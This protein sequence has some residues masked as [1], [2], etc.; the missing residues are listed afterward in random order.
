M[1]AHINLF[2]VLILL[3]FS[4]V[5]Q[6]F[7]YAQ[8]KQPNVLFI[9][10]D[11]MNDWTT[12]FDEDYPIQTPNIEKLAERG[13]FFSHAYSSS[14]ACNPSRASVM[15]STR[16]HKTGIYG[17]LSDW[18]KTLSD[19]KTIQQYFMD[20]G[21]YVVGSGK[22]FHHSLD[23]AMHDNSSFD[24]FLL[25][26][27]NKPYPPSKKNNLEWYGSINTDWGAWPEQIEQTKDYKTVQYATQFLQREHNKPFFLNVGIYKPHSPFFAPKE[28]FEPYPI[29]SIEVPKTEDE[30]WERTSGAKH[31]LKPVEW[32]W[33]G[34]E[35]AVEEDPNIYREYV[36]AYQAASTFSDKMIG[37]VIDALDNSPYRDNTIIVLWSDHGF[38]IGEKQH[39][40]KFAL[41][42]KTT[43]VPLIFVAPDQIKPG[44]VI[45]TPVD[46][47]AI[48][49][50]L[51]ELAG[52]ENYRPRRFSILDD[53][54]GK[55][56]MPLFSNPNADFP[57]ALMTYMKGN[58]AIRKD[59]WRYIQYQDGSKEL[60]DLS[61]DPNEWNNLADD[62]RFQEVIEELR[63]Y[64][65]EINAEQVSD[66]AEPGRQSL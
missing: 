37:K 58:H 25:M 15:T 31:L 24:E 57:P 20:H 19:K 49:P 1:Q 14:P 10:V 8:Q 42:E 5:A 44:I 66:L 13:A 50:T 29:N 33:A 18:R 21:Y 60:Y 36:Q 46:L 63:T 48:F 7:G 26:K 35:K 22:I 16:P 62:E 12:L 17:N 40:E 30:D 54:D 6:S 28:F 9:A 4:L 38:H 32:F 47:T 39:F 52:I 45:D 43:H 11:D 51:V 56:L 53:L 41:W 55:S 23:H 59:N 27:L 65:P 64:I 61:E 34:M 2:T 3:T